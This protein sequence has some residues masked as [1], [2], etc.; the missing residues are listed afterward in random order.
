MSSKTNGCFCVSDSL[1]QSADIVDYKTIYLI[2]MPRLL[3]VLHD[4]NHS[5]SIMFCKCWDPNILPPFWIVSLDFTR[6]NLSGCIL[7]LLDDE[8]V[9]LEGILPEEE[10]VCDTLS[11]LYLFY[12]ITYPLFYTPRLLVVLHIFMI[13]SCI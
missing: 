6:Y 10:L 13:I 9:T 5:L 7:I 3:K 4:K 8:V 1:M 12:Y 11:S 2:L